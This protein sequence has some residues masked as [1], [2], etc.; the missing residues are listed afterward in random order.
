MPSFRED[1]TVEPGLRSHIASRACRGFL[2]PNGSCCCVLR[3]SSTTRAL[4]CANVCAVFTQKSWRRRRSRA[5][6]LPSASRVL[7]R[8][9]PNSSGGARQ[10]ALQHAQRGAAGPR[11]GEHPVEQLRRR[12]WPPPPR[13]RDP[14]RPQSPATGCA[15]TGSLSHHRPAATQTSAAPHATGWLSGWSRPS[16]LREGRGFTHPSLGSFT[17]GFCAGSASVAPSW[18]LRETETTAPIAATSATAPSKVPCSR[19]ALSRSISVSRTNPPALL[20]SHALLGLG[21]NELVKLLFVVHPRPASAVFTALL[22]TGV[23]HRPTHRTDPLAELG[24]I[25]A[26]GSAALRLP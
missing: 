24:L 13:R 6:T 20:S 8:L 14:P 9:K 1:G 19:H 3:S 22:R 4:L 2:S 26:R 16:T 11:C 7:L 23:P 21:F 12:W 10:F 15:R 5:R 25:L 18:R 17:R